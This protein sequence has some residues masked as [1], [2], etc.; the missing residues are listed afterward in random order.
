[1]VFWAIICAMLGVAILLLLV[2][3][4][5]TAEARDETYLRH[6][7][8]RLADLDRAI[9]ADPND[10]TLREERTAAARQLLRLQEP[11]NDPTGA[12][13]AA[14]RPK[15]FYRII[16][17]LVALIGVPL[18][19]LGVYATIGEPDRPDVPL[20][21]QLA[22]NADSSS[23]QTMISRVET[24][25][26]SNP[27]DVEGWT[28]LARV[29]GTSQD[30][31]KRRQAVRE[32]IRLQGRS[33]ENLADLAE[34]DIQ[35]DGNLV[36]ASARA[37]LDEA[38]E[39]DPTNR[40]AA[41]YR[42]VAMEQS[43]EFDVA[44]SSWVRLRDVSPDDTEWQTLVNQRIARLE[45]FSKQTAGQQGMIEGMVANL[46]TKLIDD[47]SDMEGWTR[48]LRSYDVLNRRA[49]AA[50]ALDT[51]L[52]RSDLAPELRDRLTALRTELQ[53]TLQ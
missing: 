33:A 4:T 17:S 19:A 6:Y 11:G 23:M 25:L 38:L 47:P 40:K 18:V 10:E 53:G 35:I 32:L 29:Y 39:V 43:G 21:M 27:D 2:P 36:P 1:M 41:Y 42:T 52:S 50:M 48:L 15:Q 3:L 5:R 44:L 34:A 22:Q 26:K 37:L 16:A 24:H 14:G 13:Q 7:Q 12:R 31:A 51:V 28:I 49:D 9:I 20:A 46:R 45:D 8:R 30:Y